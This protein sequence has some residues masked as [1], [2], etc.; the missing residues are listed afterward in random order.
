MLIE[1]A[2]WQS[3]IVFDEEMQDFK[4]NVALWRKAASKVEGLKKGE[5]G[6]GEVVMARLE[7]LAKLEVP[8]VMGDKYRKVILSCLSGIGELEEH[9]EAADDVELGA[10][11]IQTVLEDLEDI[12]I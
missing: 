3:F 8:V 5:S 2:L 7:K 12:S 1:I 11:F 6:A 4:P 9:G 10:R